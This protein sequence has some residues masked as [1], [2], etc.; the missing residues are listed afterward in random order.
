M[1]VQNQYEAMYLES[2]YI[3]HHHKESITVKFEIE[4]ESRNTVYCVER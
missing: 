1:W 4:I 3:S 2:T